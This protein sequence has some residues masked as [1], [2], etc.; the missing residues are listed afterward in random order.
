MLKKCVTKEPTY[1]FMLKIEEINS[2]L[3]QQQLENIN[4]TLNMIYSVPSNSYVDY[5]KKNKDKIQICRNNNI[6]KC[7]KW[8]EKNNFKYNKVR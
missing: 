4:Q 1:H 8:C 3:G 2:I 7:I 6:Q 5:E